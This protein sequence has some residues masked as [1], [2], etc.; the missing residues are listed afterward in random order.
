MKNWY[1]LHSKESRSSVH[2]ISL[3]SITY[4]YVYVVTFDSVIF[5]QNV[6]QQYDN[7]AN[8]YLISVSYG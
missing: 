6:T 7:S 4:L 1:E 5:V 2:F 8:I 3:T